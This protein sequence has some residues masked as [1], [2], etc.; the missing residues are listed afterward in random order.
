[1]FWPSTWR[2]KGPCSPVA[3]Q[4]PGEVDCSLLHLQRSQR[5]GKLG[6]DMKKSRN[7]LFVSYVLVHGIQLLAKSKLNLVVVG[8]W[9]ALLL[10]RRLHRLSSAP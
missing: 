6:Q 8:G 5:S 2:H 10:H 1:M 9:P 7:R 4:I 3:T